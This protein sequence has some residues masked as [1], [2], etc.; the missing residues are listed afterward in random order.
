M[1]EDPDDWLLDDKDVNLPHVGVFVS[2]EEKIKLFEESL[3]GVHVFIEKYYKETC[4]SVRARGGFR[5][6]LGAKGAS[7]S[8]AVSVSVVY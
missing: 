3:K 8:T 4:I 6:S 1:F 7:R 5:F 2:R